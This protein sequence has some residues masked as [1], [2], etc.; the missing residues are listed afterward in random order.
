MDN[1]S[2]LPRK[3]SSKRTHDH[4]AKCCPFNLMVLKIFKPYFG[5]GVIWMRVWALD[6]AGHACVR[7]V[8]TYDPGPACPAELYTH[9]NLTRPVVGECNNAFQPLPLWAFVSQ[10]A[11]G[12][13]DPQLFITQ[14]LPWLNKNYPVK[15]YEHKIYR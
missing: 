4:G 2:I 3:T 1:A 14:R 15:H 7:C 5:R 11:S 9:M 8:R 10:L 12:S 6:A 13:I